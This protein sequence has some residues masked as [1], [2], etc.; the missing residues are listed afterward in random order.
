MCDKSAADVD[1][2]IKKADQA[3]F[4]VK[5]SGKNAYEFAKSF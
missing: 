2:A 3:M 1:E 5:K 4:K